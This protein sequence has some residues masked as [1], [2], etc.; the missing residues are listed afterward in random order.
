[1]KKSER[2]NIIA[3]ANGLSDEKLEKEYYDLSFDSLGTQTEKMDELGYDMSDILERKKYEKFL[4][5]KCDLL[6]ELCTKRGI[7]LWN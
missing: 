2:D 5:Q 7:E 4:S 3:W 6:E 1:M